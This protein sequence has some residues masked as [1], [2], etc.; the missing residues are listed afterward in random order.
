[1]IYVLPTKV[2]VNSITI[3]IISETTRRRENCIERLEPYIGA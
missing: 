2:K 1:L 3:P